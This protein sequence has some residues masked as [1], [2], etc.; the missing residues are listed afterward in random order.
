MT[1][2]AILQDLVTSLDLYLPWL[3][4]TLETIELAVPST[5]RLLICVPLIAWFAVLRQRHATSPAQLHRVLM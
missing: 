3:L 2:I 1:Q 4:P 5:A